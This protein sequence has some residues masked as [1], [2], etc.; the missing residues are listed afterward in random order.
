MLRYEKSGPVAVVTL[1]RPEVRNALNVALK[2]AI[3]AAMARAE[4]DNDIAVVVLT[5]EDP[6]FCAGLDLREVGEQG[7]AR[8]ADARVTRW[9]DPLTKPVI[10]AVNGVA[11]TGGL[12]LALSCDILIGSERAKFGDTHARVGL[13]P[14][15][16][17]ST[18]LPA[19][20]GL[21]RAKE[22][23]FTGNF[24]SAE[25]AFAVGLITHLVPH[26]QLMATALSIA[27]DI[28]GNDR[29]TVAALN[30]LYDEVD[31]LAPGDGLQREAER[32]S[33]WTQTHDQGRGVAQKRAAIIARGR[34][35][36]RKRSGRTRVERQSAAY[37]FAVVRTVDPLYGTT[38]L[39]SQDDG[40]LESGSLDTSF[41]YR[42]T[43]GLS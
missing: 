43:G 42:D 13:L 23:S 16:G 41:G 15:G 19:A 27:N 3:R 11:I 10:G 29:E 1:D 20:V 33:A 24:L 40:G 30:A 4:D 35:Q 34:A 22:M 25:E 36:T 32:A 37:E 2:D 12:E 9:W 6:A 8:P 26:A 5:G 7:V 38:G 18:R 39:G 21:R 14:F 17:L 31:A 28:A